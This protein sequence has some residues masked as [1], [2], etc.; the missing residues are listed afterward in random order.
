VRSE[1]L[2]ELLTEASFTLLFVVVLARAVRR[3]LRAHIEATLLFAA[4]TLVLA[5]G[6]AEDALGWGPDPLRSH[7]KW[8]LV[9][10]IPYI[11]LRLVADF[12]DVPRPM[13]RGAGIG[14]VILAV[15]SFAAPSPQPFEV[16]AVGALYFFGLEAYAAIAFV[17]TARRSGGVT[18][19][20]MQ[21]AAAGSLLL[22]L[23]LL[24]VPLSTGL[25]A[26]ATLWQILTQLLALVA[27]MAYFLGFAPP[28]WLRRAWQEPE[29]RAFL[30]RAASLPRLPDTAGIVRELEHGAATSTG[31]P[32]A[33][34]GLWDE[35]DRVLRFTGPKGESFDIAPGQ[36]IAGRAFA[37]QRAIH[38]TD[39]PLDDPAYAGVY[40]SSGAGAVLAAPITAGERRLGVLAVFAPY[41]PLFVEDDL[42]L[43]QL[44][45]DQAAVI[46]ESRALIDQAAWVRAR[47]EA[48][49]L[50]DDFLSAAA[51]DLKTPL[52]TLVG[53]AQLLVRK[54]RLRPDA[55]PDVAGLVRIEQAAMRL[56]GLVLDLL[57]V[58][59]AERG[60]LVGAT[61]VVELVE[62]AKAACRRHTSERHPCVLEAGAPVW[63]VGDSARLAQLLD[64][65]LENAAKYSPAGGEVRV[66]V[67]E[68]DGQARLSVADQGVG[69]PAQ[70]LPR[71][72]DRY[73]RG[74]NVDDRRFPGMGLGLYICRVIAEQHGGCIW[75]S[76]TPGAG[77][78]FHVALPLAPV[79]AQAQ[80]PILPAGEPTHA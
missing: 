73:H 20:R 13:L 8:A 10:A 24:V 25:P 48:T 15:G 6:R 28:T 29:L 19:R 39:A 9:L 49:R 76:S 43:V 38:S 63:S 52:T 69:I 32:V 62:I 11:L 12:S 74:T 37:E 41:P 44:L 23:A 4:P 77:S 42:A 26:F 79:P 36:L 5:L 35:T 51:H 1:E 27:G 7:I 65:L 71:I 66:R 47:E 18:R 70:D 21:A 68:E 56:R 34:I 16:T 17:R 45:A 67:W 80:E 78:I 59:R 58:S 31:A 55:P 54:A 64:N 22:G 40:R 57:D 75:A 30:G 14:L 61:E 3:P 33:T 46:L 60:R 2:L 50:K 72:F 53:D